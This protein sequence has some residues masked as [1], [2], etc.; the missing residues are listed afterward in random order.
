MFGAR[1][2]F[3]SR[4]G[5][6]PEDITDEWSQQ[7]IHSLLAGT[8]GRGK[9]LAPKT[10]R[11]IMSVFNLIFSWGIRRAERGGWHVPAKPHMVKVKMHVP[12][13][14]DFDAKR[15]GYT[16]DI[17]AETAD[18]AGRGNFASPLHRNSGRRAVR[19]AVEAYFF[20]RRNAFGG[21]NFAADFLL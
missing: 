19:A 18:A 11:D 7:F 1:S 21:T 13:G 14:S 20:N 9:P 10:V 6:A 2:Y 12:R 4:A 15:A 16:G 8:S 5:T 3:A 17:F